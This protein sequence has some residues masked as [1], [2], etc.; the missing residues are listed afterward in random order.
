MRY[1]GVPTCPYCRKRVNL[2]RTWSL[3]RQGE[4]QCPRCGGISNI[5]LSPLIYVFALLAIFAGGSMYFFH[6]FILDDIDLETVIYV[7]VPFGVFFLISLFMV[8]L[9]KPVIKKVS[10][11]EFDKRRRLRPASSEPQAYQAP[12]AGDY[13][14]RASHRPGPIRQEERPRPQGGAVNQEAFSRA[15]QRA[16]VENDQQ[17][18]RIQY[19]SQRVTPPAAAA[20]PQNSREADLRNPRQVSEISR[21]EEKIEKPKPIPESPAR[22]AGEGEL[23]KEQARPARP[24]VPATAYARPNGYAARSSAYQNRQ[25]PAASVAGRPQVQNTQYQANA[26][27]QAINMPHTSGAHT[28]NASEN[29]PRQVSPPEISKG[30]ERAIPTVSS[31]PGQVNAVHNVNVTGTFKQQGAAIQ[32]GRTVY[33]QQRAAAVQ[34]YQQ[35]QPQQYRSAY[36]RQRATQQQY[37]QAKGTEDGVRY[38]NPA[39]NEQRGR[40]AYRNNQNNR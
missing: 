37:S 25:S 29:A 36:Q 35:G 27:Q 24:A 13:A 30:N 22:P 19:P 3:K 39:F 5:F 40:E 18:Q 21:R 1:F 28:T 6:K 38:E 16:A 14:P 7:I 32:Q 11:A 17:S 15:K 9:E 8:Y 33:D 26:Y 10:K 34:A 20:Q 23:P 2:I 31:Q 12:A 4:Y